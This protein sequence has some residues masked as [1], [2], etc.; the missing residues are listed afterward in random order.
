M[1]AMAWR[2]E[3]IVGNNDNEQ[4]PTR[5][6]VTPCWGLGSQ[7]GSQNI[8]GSRWVWV[9]MKPGV[10]TAPEASSSGL[11]VA[12]Q[13]LPHLDDDAQWRMRTSA[14]KAGRPVPATTVPPT[15]KRSALGWIGVGVG[16]SY[17]L[18]RPSTPS[19][20]AGPPRPGTPGSPR[21]RIS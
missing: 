15:T 17:G 3:S 9:S 7:A 4:L 6:V 13:P 16:L 21:G 18:R 11:A 1:S 12:G 20:A 19:P 5:A 8:C 10:T 14:G 2:W